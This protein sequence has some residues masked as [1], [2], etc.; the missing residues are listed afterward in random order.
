[1]TKALKKNAFE[2]ASCLFDRDPDDWR[3][4]RW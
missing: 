2:A 3:R 4:L 1:M